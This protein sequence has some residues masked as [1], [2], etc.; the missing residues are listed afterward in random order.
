M[1]KREQKSGRGGVSGAETAAAREKRA[2]EALRANL[3]RRKSAGRP[4]PGE[5]SNDDGA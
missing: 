2:A 4:K 1:A 3:R 5:S